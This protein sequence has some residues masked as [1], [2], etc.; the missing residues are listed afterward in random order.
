MHHP[1]CTSLPVEPF[2]AT[3]VYLS[4]A[5]DSGLEF[6]I[7]ATLRAL[8]KYDALVEL[9][10][11]HYVSEDVTFITLPGVQRLVFC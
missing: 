11:S 7:N 2:R 3:Y 10:L 4:R 6:H 9:A 8:S 5:T 1:P